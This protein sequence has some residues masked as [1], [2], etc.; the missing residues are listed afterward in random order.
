MASIVPWLGVTPPHVMAEHSSILRAPL[1]AASRASPS[2]EQQTSIIRI[3]KKFL[4]L[5]KVLIF[6]RFVALNEEFA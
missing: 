2:E 3:V 6:S 4:I 1:A 5:V